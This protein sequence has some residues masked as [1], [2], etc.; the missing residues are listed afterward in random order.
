[1]LDQDAVSEYFAEIKT[2]LFLVKSEF[3]CGE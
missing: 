1:M 2:G 3:D